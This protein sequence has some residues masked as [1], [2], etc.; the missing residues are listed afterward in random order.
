[1]RTDADT[2]QAT[3]DAAAIR[4]FIGIFVARG[5]QFA[6]RPAQQAARRPR[7]QAACSGAWC[8]PARPCGPRRMRSGPGGTSRV[9]QYVLLPK[10]AGRQH[11]GFAGQGATARSRASATCLQPAGHVRRYEEDNFTSNY[12]SYLPSGT[13]S[14][15]RRAYVARALMYALETRMEGTAQVEKRRQLNWGGNLAHP[16]QGPT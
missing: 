5:P 12:D 1:M 13:G 3:L 14:Q 7:A 2:R 11:R 6:A 10:T 9:S 8:A 4:N 15:A 16:R